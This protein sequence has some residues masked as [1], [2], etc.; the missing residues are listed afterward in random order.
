[1]N[2]KELSNIFKKISKW[3]SKKIKVLSIKTRPFNTIEIFSNIINKT[4]CKNKNILYIFCSGEKKYAYEKIKELNNFVDGI[5]ESE[6]LKNKF[7]YIFLE[8]I[9]EINEFY[10][11]VIFD[12]ITLFSKV[13]NEYIR[14][15]IEE[16]YWNC[17]KII[18]YASEYIFPIG[19]RLEINYM[20]EKSPMIE[21]RLMNTR[22][23]L[24]DDIPLSLF[25]YFKWFK[26]NKRI[27]LIVVPSEEKLNKV[28]NHYYS[29]LKSVGIRVVRYNKNQN[30]K[31]ISD[32]IEE[33]SSTLFIITNN[34][35]Q[36][37]RNIPNVNVIMLFADDVYYSCKKILY[38]CG[39]INVS[40]DMQCEAIMVSKEVSEE[41]DKAKVITRSFNKS[42][43]EKQYLKY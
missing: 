33:C 9:N 2:Y 12:D 21:P 10:D 41:M 38:I 40:E 20:I 1:M 42:L 24:Q 3:D 27:V 6:I 34:C 5:I 26:D 25:E 28:Y 8:E 37:I 14:E 30:F 22:I 43:W 23:K 19:E 31:F 32:I 4:I 29:T 17:N 35:G 13:S 7:K 11:L 15:A 36:Y 39:A 16:I 18:V